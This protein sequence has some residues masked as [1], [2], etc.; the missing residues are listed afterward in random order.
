MFYSSHDGITWN[1]MEENNEVRQAYIHYQH[2]TTLFTTKHGYIV[3]T[4]TKNM[5]IHMQNM[6]IHL[7][8]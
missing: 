2:T 8:I 3:P 6:L 1:E 5:F 4:V 7:L